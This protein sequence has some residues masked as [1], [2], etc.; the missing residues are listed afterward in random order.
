MKP[1]IGRVTDRT[2]WRR[3]RRSVVGVLSTAY[4]LCGALAAGLLTVTRTS[5]QWI[6]WTGRG[7]STHLIEL[8]EAERTRRL[9]HR[10][11]RGTFG[12][13][14]E[15]SAL[16]VVATP[17]LALVTEWWVV[18]SYGYR[19]IHSWVIGTWTGTDPQ[20]LVFAGVATLITLS[21]AFTLLN[22]GLI[23]ATLLVMGPIFGIG[24]TR[25]GLTFE[26]FGTVGIPEATAFAG[27][28]AFCFGVPIGVMG[29][30]I[31]T[32]LRS[33]VAHFDGDRG[34]DSVSWKS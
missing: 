1:K 23:P 34:P 3:L 4:A 28:V 2:V 25:Y 17:V 15:L 13:R 18:N 29:F 6:L 24:F 5:G 11:R 8:R 32:T 27:F 26:P 33:G 20:L 22:S 7:V 16:A 10:L 12:V 19:H 14:Y 21:S 31:G 9:L 30:L